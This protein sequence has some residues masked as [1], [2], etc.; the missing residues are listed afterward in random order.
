MN[1]KL[2]NMRIGARL[3]FAFAVVL[4]LTVLLNLVGVAG[5]RGIG[6]QTTE[7]NFVMRKMRLSEQWKGIVY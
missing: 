3:A 6:H 4:T 5:L 7:M 2:K 1:M